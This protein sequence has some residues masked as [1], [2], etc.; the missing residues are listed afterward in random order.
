MA[1]L[2]NFNLKT[3]AIKTA[4]T[5]NWEEA[6]RLNKILLEENPED[7]ETLNRL[8]LA[9]M[10]LGKTSDAK[11]VS[12]KVFDLDPL[13]PIALKN[14]KKIKEKTICASSTTFQINNNFLEETGK[15]KIVE[16]V[17]IAQ[18]KVIEE[19]RI[20]ESV[21]LCI[22]RSKI[23]VL[24]DGKQYVGVLPDDIGRR[25]IKFIKSGNK[26]EAYIKSICPHK[27]HVFIKEMKRVSKYK[28]QPSFIT[29]S[30]SVWDL[31]KNTKIKSF[32]VHLEDEDED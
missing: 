4:L 23:F 3:Q 2:L 9:Y 32:K 24:K 21:E 10:V 19:L 16:L 6:V 27:V 5:G 11:K 15:T 22:K 18:A 14:L 31:D 7:I 17:N 12:Q 1:N 26:Y 30:D 13:N 20:G 29:I 8:A 25:L 28:N